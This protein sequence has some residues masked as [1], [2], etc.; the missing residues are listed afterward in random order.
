MMLCLKCWRICMLGYL[1][2]GRYHILEEQNKIWR[3][4]VFVDGYGSIS[5]VSGIVRMHLKHL[6]MKTLVLYR[7]K[8]LLLVKMWCVIP[9]GGPAL[10]G[11]VGTITF[12]LTRT[13]SLSGALDVSDLE[14][15][16]CSWRQQMLGCCSPREW[17]EHGLG[18]PCSVLSCGT[19]WS[20]ESNSSEFFFSCHSWA[21]V[22]NY[23]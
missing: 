21:S 14:F 13:T 16:C 2:Q 23:T 6:K 15:W 4:L 5:R 18:V 9:L 3:I 11:V 17:R 7:T 22:K 19:N 8:I 20:Q 10:P 1:E 12:Q